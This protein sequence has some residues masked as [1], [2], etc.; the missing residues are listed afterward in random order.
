VPQLLTGHQQLRL[1]GRSRKG[2]LPNVLG[3]VDGGR[4]DPQ[5]PAQPEP[6]PGQQL[7]EPRNPMQ[8][9]TDLLPGRLDPEPAV[10]VQQP[11]AIQDGQGADV[12]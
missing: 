8:P 11:G 5:R 9:P 10:G 12:L 3:E 6:G 7:P 2:E 4:V 1:I